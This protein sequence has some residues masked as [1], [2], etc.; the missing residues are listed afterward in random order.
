M[1]I[2]IT[3]D[4][5]GDF[6]RFSLASFP[7]Q[8]ELTKEDYMI[9]CGNFGGVWSGNKLEQHW[10]IWLEGQPFTTLFVDGNHENYDFLHN[11]PVIQWHGGTAQAI[12][13]SVLYL[14][15]GQLYDICGKRNL[16]HGWSQQSRYPRRHSRA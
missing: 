1:A 7:E 16:Y 6:S 9:I 3:G 2:F 12:R 14:M 15:R 5:H 10:L 11:Y 13:P 8:V 4:T